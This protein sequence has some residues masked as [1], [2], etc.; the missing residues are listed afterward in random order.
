MAESLQLEQLIRYRL[1]QQLS[2]HVCRR[3]DEGSS[4]FTEQIKYMFMPTNAKEK[5]AAERRS[6]MHGRGGPLEEKANVRSYWD[7]WG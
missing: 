1:L 5:Q 2:G 7:C 4:G 6:G 3:T